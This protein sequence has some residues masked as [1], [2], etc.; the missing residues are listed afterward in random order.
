MAGMYEKG[1]RAIMGGN[2]DLINDRISAVLI[3]TT[4]YTPNLSTDESQADIPAAAQIAEKTLT[5]NTLT[6]STFRADDTT[7]P[8]VQGNQV[9]AVVILRDSG[10]YETSTL[11]CFLDNGTGFPITPN[12]EDITIRWD[13][14]ENGIFKL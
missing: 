14:G 9:G 13:T 5:G 12:G 10:E 7:F 2:V 3:D 11:L 8:T 4:I 1:V 6:D